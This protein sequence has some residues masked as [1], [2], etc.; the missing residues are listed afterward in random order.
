MGLTLPTLGS[1]AGGAIGSFGG[2]MGT[3]AGATLGGAGMSYLADRYAQARERERNPLQEDD[4]ARSLLFAGIGA[5][6]MSGLATKAGPLLKYGGL[7]AETLAKSLG[8][9]AAIRAYHGEDPSITG[10]DVKGALLGIP[11]NLIGGAVIN[12][13]VGGTAEALG[14]SPSKLASKQISN[15][16]NQQDLANYQNAQAEN[17]R[18]LELWQAGEQNLTDHGPSALAPDVMAR[19]GKN[20]SMIEQYEK[21]LVQDTA[22]LMKMGKK[23]GHLSPGWFAKQFGNRGTVIAQEQ[24]MRGDTGELDPGASGRIFES[25][26][27][28]SNYRKDVEGEI[29]AMVDP[30]MKDWKALTPKARKDASGVIQL[31]LSD[32]PNAEKHLEG[33]P[34]IV[35]NTYKALRA[36]YQRE[37]PEWEK[38]GVPISEAHKESYATRIAD[39]QHPLYDASMDTELSARSRFEHPQTERSRLYVPDDSV[40]FFL[41][42]HLPSFSRRVAYQPVIDQYL[43]YKDNP[44]VKSFLGDLM[45]PEGIQGKPSELASWVAGKRYEAKVKW[46]PFSAAKNMTQWRWAQA[47]MDP[48]QRSLARMIESAPEAIGM[49]EFIRRPETAKYDFQDG[50]LVPSMGKKALVKAPFEMAEARNWEKAK[51]AGMA[52]EISRSKVYQDALA[53]GDDMAQALVKASNDPETMSRAMRSGEVRSEMT[54]LGGEPGFR[55]QIYDTILRKAPIL[56]PMLQFS[57]FSMGEP[58]I[59]FDTFTRSGQEKA[60]LRKG[61]SEDASVV[62]HKRALTQLRSGVERAMKDKFIPKADA[63]AKL[64]EIDADIKSVNAQIDEI[65][66]RNRTRAVSTLLRTMGTNIGT[67]IVRNSIKYGLVLGLITDIGDAE[68]EKLNTAANMQAG[69]NAIPGSGAAT[70]LMDWTGLSPDRKSSSAMDRNVAGMIDLIPGIGPLNNA[71]PGQPISRTISKELKGAMRGNKPKAPSQPKPR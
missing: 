43:Q 64:K 36:A 68:L 69:T 30:V 29:R 11:L 14:I 41:N 12:K 16:K 4:Q 63:R 15:V 32:T 26:R 23:G 54:Q 67:D 61:F 42:R 20:R 52:E 35:R 18:A 34:D 62:E 3:L 38:A 8:T 25:A 51:S 28:A 2:P 9:N 57:R 37:I 39:E 46:N 19:M 59:V 33:Q 49:G 48:E 44:T 31:A 13:A 47:N 24:L 21:P 71:I 45:N 40:D 58:E 5:I 53:S 17:A 7:A 60:I 70:K 55:P 56:R 27:A 22:K 50:D 66:P 10:E 65:A 6:P 1:Y